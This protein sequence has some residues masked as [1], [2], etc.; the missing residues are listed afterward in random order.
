M[1]AAGVSD[2]ER[3]KLLEQWE[4]VT[5]RIFGLFGKDSRTKVGD[6][7]RLAYK[8]VAED[9]ETRTHNQIMAG[10]RDL[11][12]AHPIDQAVE[13]GLI[14][15]DL[16]DRPEECRYLLWSYEEHL[17]QKLGSGAT[18]DENERMEI[19]RLRALDS[20]EHIF[21]RNPPVGKAW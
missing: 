12:Q 1:T 7:V 10:L 13:E 20:I 3:R 5:F 4:R 19:W 8:I 11:G 6:Y 15:R 21:P 2:N 14:R 16:Y 17:A 9:I 18:I